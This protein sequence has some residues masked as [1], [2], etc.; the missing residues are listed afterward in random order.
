MGVIDSLGKKA[1]TKVREWLDKPE[2][3]FC[4]DRIPDQQTGWFGSCNICDFTLYRYPY[5]YYIESKAT[6]ADRFE[7]NMITDYQRD[8]MFKKSQIDGVYAYVI[9]L[10]ASYKR[11]FVLDI[12]H[13]V[14]LMN[15]GTKSINI[16]KID[17]WTIP[18]REISTIPSNRKILLDYDFEDAKDIF[19]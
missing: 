13:I 3:G 17:K 1:E 5:F 2:D 19:K 8:N 14:S 7:F 15:S 6:E 9:V 16:K 11:A 12:Q 10:F 18:Y 4:F